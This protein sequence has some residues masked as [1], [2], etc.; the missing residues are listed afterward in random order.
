MIP[1]I[2]IM[3]PKGS[4]KTT[5]AEIVT[6]VTGWKHENTSDRIIREYCQEKNLNPETMNKE[7]HREELWEVG[8]RIREEHG[9][10][11]LV[12]LVETPIVVGIRSIHELEYCAD[13][14]NLLIW[15]LRDG[16][17]S[18]SDPTLKFDLEDMIR[19]C[20]AFRTSFYIKT[21]FGTSSVFN[22]QCRLM[23]RRLLEKHGE[24]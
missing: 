22:S 10:Y 3:G 20:H 6:E 18:R 2:C 16:K 11:S 24:G 19:A 23:A 12:E 8:E 9:V 7:E 21:N 15:M 5:F 17:H 1:K 4:G 14:F 13:N